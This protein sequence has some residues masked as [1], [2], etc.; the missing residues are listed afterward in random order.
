MFLGLLDPDPDPL[1]RC[2]D[3]DIVKKNLDSYHFVTSL[4]LFIKE[5]DVSVPSKVKEEKC[6]DPQ[7]FNFFSNLKGVGT[8]P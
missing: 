6:K 1:V 2:T 7:H 5:N 4:C 8:S 3:M